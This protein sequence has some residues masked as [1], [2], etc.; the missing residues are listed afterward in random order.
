MAFGLALAL[1]AGRMRRQLAGEPRRRLPRVV[2]LSGTWNESGGG[3]L[4]VAIGPKRRQ[5]SPAPA[6]SVRTTAGSSAP[7]P[8]QGT[9]RR[10]RRRMARSRSPTGIAT[11]SR[12]NC[13]L[14]VTG[15][16]I[17]SG[18]QMSGT[19][20]GSRFLR[21]R[22][23]RDAKRN[24]R[25]PQAIGARRRAS[26]PAL[27]QADVDRL[28][29]DVPRHRGDD[30]RARVR[31]RRA[32]RRNVEHR[33]ER[34]QLEDVM[35]RRARRRSAGP[36]VVRTGRADLAACRRATATSTVRARASA[37]TVGGNIPQHPVQHVVRAVADRRVWIVDDQRVAATP[38]GAPLQA[39]GGDM[40]SPSCVYF[41]GIWPP[42]GHAGRSQR[43]HLHGAAAAAAA[44]LARLA[45]VGRGSAAGR[46]GVGFRAAGRSPASST[47]RTRSI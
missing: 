32:D 3:T 4:H 41:A 14:V 31:R 24:D 39:S 19:L 28:A 13:S 8:G 46:A 40:S 23:A 2:D 22:D 20:P 11:L 29:A 34:E 35:M 5:P 30:R 17:I 10:H 16:M 1:V 18:T 33:V 9:H 27:E 25:A 26:R 38:S 6:A 47:A 12:A 15:R 44:A 37:M 36:A 7:C 43:H 42:S 21:R 45:R